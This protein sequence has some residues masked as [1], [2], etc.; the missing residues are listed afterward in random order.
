MA[1]FVRAMDDLSVPRANEIITN[2][3]D[4]ATGRFL[5]EAPSED[6]FDYQ[7][8]G[9]ILKQYDG[10]SADRRSAFQNQ[11]RDL[12]TD[13]QRARA[14][15]IALSGD[16]LTEPNLGAKLIANTPQSR[17]QRIIDLDIEAFGSTDAELA[18]NFR[19][20]LLRQSGDTYDR[21]PNVDQYLTALETIQSG[22]R[23]DS[24]SIS[25]S[26]A[27]VKEFANEGE[28]IRNY[29]N[30][31]W[32]ARRTAAYVEKA[33]GD[34]N[35]NSIEIE[36]N[37]DLPETA[38]DVDIAIRNQYTGNEYIELKSPTESLSKKRIRDYLENS[39]RKFRDISSEIDNN[40]GVRVLEIDRRNS[41]DLDPEAIRQAIAKQ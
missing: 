37:G 33:R 35:I 23:G 3:F 16:E 19:R 11:L 34:N 36:F 22:I 6:I 4:F 5:F 24:V 13:Q 39:N 18:A 28:F 31:V 20:N 1:T 12:A 27:L 30:A 29:E 40:R 25:G 2:E 17:F 9:R 21:Q 10:L 8:I 41:D 14:V 32:E 26:R 38:P 7:H 15:R